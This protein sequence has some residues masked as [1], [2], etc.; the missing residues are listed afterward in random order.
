[1]VSKN[2]DTE[3]KSAFLLSHFAIKDMAGDSIFKR[4][5]SVIPKQ[6]S[7]FERSQSRKKGIHAGSS[8]ALLFS[9]LKEESFESIRIAL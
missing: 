9:S 1:M 5:K 3:L 4:L 2:V 8:R 6:Q 7:Q